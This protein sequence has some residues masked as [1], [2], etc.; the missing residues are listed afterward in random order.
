MR[1]YRSDIVGFCNSACR[2]LEELHGMSMKKSAINWKGS[3]RYQNNAWPT[4]H[5]DLRALDSKKRASAK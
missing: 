1:V 4:K 3:G 5:R 2:C